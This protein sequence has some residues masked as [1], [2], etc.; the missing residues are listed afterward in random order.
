MRRIRGS[1][2]L[3]IS[4]HFKHRV[5]FFLEILTPTLRWDLQIH[6]ILPREKGDQ[7]P[8]LLIRCQGKMKYKIQIP[9]IYR[10]RHKHLIKVLLIVFLS[11][12]TSTLCLKMVA[13][14]MIT[15]FKNKKKIRPQV[16]KPL[17][18]FSRN[19]YWPERHRI[20]IPV[21]KQSH[22]NTNKENN[23]IKN[24]NY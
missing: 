3:V 18:L 10:G 21:K 6:L 4:M 22:Q 12:R 11:T 16:Q 20:D 9:F 5:Y 14:R 24:N 13:I 2:I 8:R 19:K 7:S 17:K 23:I 1:M 15:W